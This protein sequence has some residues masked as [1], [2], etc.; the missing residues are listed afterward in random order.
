MDNYRSLQ[1]DAVC[2]D[3]FPSLFDIAPTAVETVVPYYLGRRDQHAMFDA[4]R[5]R[6][7]HDY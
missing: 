4:I 7:R 6:A 1:V 3:E 5:E 2:K